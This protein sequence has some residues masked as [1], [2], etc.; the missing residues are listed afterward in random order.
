MSPAT[1]VE[2]DRALDAV[3][4]TLSDQRAAHAGAGRLQEI[5]DGATGQERKLDVR[6]LAPSSFAVD[7]HETHRHVATAEHDG[8]VWTV[9]REREA[10]GSHVAVPGE[11]GG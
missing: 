8:L 3:Q 10:R 11:D 7:D 1:D 5:A 4:T 6:P 2:I 9:R